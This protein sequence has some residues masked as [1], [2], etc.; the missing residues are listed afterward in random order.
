MQN[1]VYSIAKTLRIQIVYRTRSLLGNTHVRLVRSVC[2]KAPLRPIIQFVLRSL[3]SV[4]IYKMFSAPNGYVKWKTRG[5]FPLFFSQVYKLKLFSSNK[6]SYKLMLT[7]P[8][9]SLC[10]LITSLTIIIFL[11]E[12]LILRRELFSCLIFESLGKLYADCI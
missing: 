6:K 5:I 1:H 12:S 2:L 4:L 8:F 7:M 9:S 3:V 10:G 11:K